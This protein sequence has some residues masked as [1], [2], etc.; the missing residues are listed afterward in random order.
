MIMQCEISTSSDG[1]QHLFWQEQPLSNGKEEGL[2]KPDLKYEEQDL[3]NGFEW[4]E[5][6]VG[7]ELAEFIAS[8]YCS[9]PLSTA[10]LAYLSWLLS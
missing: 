1:R 4:C 5:L 10:P 2:I 8:Q 7:E 9:Q 6:T 3:P